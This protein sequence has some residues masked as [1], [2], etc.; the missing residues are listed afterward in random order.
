MVYLF[1]WGNT[2][3]RDDFSEQGPMHLWKKVELCP[4][5][6]PMLET[7][8]RCHDLYLATNAE[9]S[10]EADIRK[11]LN[12]AGIGIYIKGIFCFRT[13][14]VKKPSP[15]FFT[16]VVRKLGCS[17]SDLTMVGDDPEKDTLWALQNGARAVLYDPAAR[18]HHAGCVR[19]GDL[20]ELCP[21]G[22]AAVVGAIHEWL[23]SPSPPKHAPQ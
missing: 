21:D 4:N 5:A 3:M 14:G 13:L 19:I 9:D 7:L 17:P 18:Y 22:D 16:A 15:E 2:L 12:R 20:M 10:D 6:R 1:D 8:S 11:A 23:P